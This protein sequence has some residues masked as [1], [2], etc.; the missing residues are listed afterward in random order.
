MVNIE[1]LYSITENQLNP[2]LASPISILA[3]ALPEHQARLA[4]LLTASFHKV[5]TCYQVVSVN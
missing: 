5:P 2:A 4:P 1:S 3:L